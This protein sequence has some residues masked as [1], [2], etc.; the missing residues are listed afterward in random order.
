MQASYPGVFVTIGFFVEDI[1]RR[2][3][4]VKNRDL[5]PSL[6]IEDCLLWQDLLK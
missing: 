3:T 5:T 1:K 2:N 6:S 4:I